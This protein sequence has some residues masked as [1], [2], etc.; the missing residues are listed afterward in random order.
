MKRKKCVALLFVLCLCAGTQG[1]TF[2]VDDDAPGDPRPRDPNFSDPK[3]DGSQQHPFDSI[4]KAVDAAQDGDA[5][6]VAPGRYLSLNTW[7]Y[8]ELKFKGKNIRL[9]GSAS[10]DF[11]V[12][13][14]TVLCGVIIFDGTEDPNCL[15]QGFKIQNYSYGGILGNKTHATLSHCIIS[16]NGPCGA[17]VIKD[18]YGR[19]ANCLIVDNT[20][21][22]DCGVL[23]VVSG[24]HELI[25]CTIAN[26]QSNVELTTAGLPPEGHITV[27]NCIIYGNQGTGIYPIGYGVP[28]IDQVSY[29]LVADANLVEAATGRVMRSSSDTKTLLYADPCF[30][31]PGHWEGTTIPPEGATRVG[32]GSG[33]GTQKILVEGDYRLQT[34]GWRWS[35]QPIHGS[36]WYFDTVTS[37]A[38]DAGDPMDGLGAE[39]ERVPDDPEGRY[40]TNHAID[41]GAYGGTAQAS[42][43]PTSGPIPGAGAV[44]LHDYWPLPFSRELSSSNRWS[45]HD[46]NGTVRQFN[47]SGLSSGPGG[48]VCRL[49]TH[50]DVTWVA[51]VNCYYVERTFYLTTD[52]VPTNPSLQPPQR[53]QA[54]YPAYL[55]DG[56]TIQAPYDPFATGGSQYQSALVERGTLAEVLT[57]TSMDPTQF[58]AGVWPDVIAL[59][60][61]NA[62]GT[63][64]DPIAIFA[65]GFGPLLLAGQRIDG[66]TVGSRTFGN[67]STGGTGA[68]RSTRG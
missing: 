51:V 7:A 46:P 16:G 53:V 30:V 38:V 25:N 58:L 9:T 18:V 24:C 8:A 35:P 34:E 28:V 13:N 12:A 27:R 3:E 57:G 59:K 64:G 48:R 14:Q 6:I 61:K 65:R 42:L 45:M 54:Q 11:D 44:D 49:S 21:F 60:A 47:V 17:T 4:Q 2:Y 40:G 29:S 31:Q 56:S 41:L 36:H 37:P 62:D 66:A 32:R 5:I 19:I 52:T 22:H 68:T 50:G 55:I 67:T 33:T 26:N 10:T 1:V 15:L 23:P 39:L 43:A 20:T 63:A